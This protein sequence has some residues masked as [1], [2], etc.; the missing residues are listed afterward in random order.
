MWI[1]VLPVLDLPH[2][3]KHSCVKLEFSMC[4]LESCPPSEVWLHLPFT[5]QSAARSLLCLLFS[6]LTSILS[7]S[8]PTMCSSI[9]VAFP[10]SFLVLGSP[11]WSSSS[12][13]VHLGAFLGGRL[14]LLGFCRSKAP[15]GH[16]GK[17]SGQC[18]PFPGCAAS[19]QL[20]YSLQARKE[21]FCAAPPVT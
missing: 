17:H 3:E 19:P 12:L 15:S 6:R 8:L 10:E 9:L 13:P 20:L 18:V 11:N 4:Q 21:R 5:L 16:F 14:V 2:G 1:P 7:L